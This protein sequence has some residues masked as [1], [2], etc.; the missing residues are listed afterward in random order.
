MTEEGDADVSVTVEVV[1]EKEAVGTT[2]RLIRDILEGPVVVAMAAAAALTN[3]KVTRV[4]DR[5]RTL[6]SVVAMEKDVTIGTRREEEEEGMEVIGMDR[7]VD[8]MVMVDPLMESAEEED[9]IERGI[10]V[11]VNMVDD[12][13]RE[14]KVMAKVKDW[15]G[16]RIKI[17]SN[18]DMVEVEEA[19]MKSEEEWEVVEVGEEG[20]KRNEIEEVMVMAEVIE[21]SV[22]KPKLIHLVL[23]RV[24]QL[25][26]RLISIEDLKIIIEGKDMVVRMATENME[27][28]EDRTVMLTLQV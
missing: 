13:R 6:E 2:V 12:T 3:S 1:A 18:K 5:I 17:R 10:E 28:I 24:N 23:H 20:E 22:V 4:E 11:T 16:I 15:T 8:S 21:T 14:K 9:S 25:D 26:I 27:R 19:K 7:I